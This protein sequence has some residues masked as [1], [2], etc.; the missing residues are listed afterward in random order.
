LLIFYR[1][2]QLVGESHALKSS[3]GQV[4]LGQLSSF[5]ELL[6]PR[7][8]HIHLSAACSDVHSSQ[9]ATRSAG[10]FVLI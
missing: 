3:A 4:A 5:I 1:I 6:P 10:L 9:P 2:M 7:Y 8:P